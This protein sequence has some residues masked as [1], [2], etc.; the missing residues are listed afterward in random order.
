MRQ[1]SCSND[2]QCYP[3]GVTNVPQRLIQCVSGV[4]TCYDCF[5]RD[6]ST[7]RCTLT[8]ATPANCYYFNNITLECVDNRKS[9]VVAFALS[10]TLSSVGAAN[11]YI[12]QNGLGAGQL[13]LFLSIFVI[14]YCGIC[15]PLCALCCVENE[16]VKVWV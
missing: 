9:Q 6:Q 5:T 2:S 12:G 3:Q 11:F 8:V 7:G 4:C 1:S 14:M 13:V 10:L 15:T 16:N